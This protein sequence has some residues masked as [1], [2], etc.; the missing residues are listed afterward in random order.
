MQ[1]TT[2]GTFTLGGVLLFT[3]SGS[4]LLFWLAIF[5]VLLGTLFLVHV[6]I[7]RRKEAREAHG[8]L[9]L[10]GGHKT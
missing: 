8:L 4:P 2:G 9:P 1:G 3:L 5:S 6:V 10:P 7:K